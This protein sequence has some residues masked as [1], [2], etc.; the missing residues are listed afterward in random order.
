MYTL[1]GYAIFKQPTLFGQ[2]YKLLGFTRDKPEAA[3]LIRNEHLALP[4]DTVMATEVATSYQNEH[5]EWHAELEHCP[6]AVIIE[7]SL[8]EAGVKAYGPFVNAQEAHHHTW[9]LDS[10]SRTMIL[11]LEH[12]DREL[13]QKSA[14]NLKRLRDESALYHEIMQDLQNL[15]LPHGRCQPRSD[16]ACTH[17]NAQDRLDTALSVYP[18]PRIVCS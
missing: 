6:K 10:F 18:G 2:A 8:W 9:K 4:L 1:H 5:P 7:G 16:K 14:V 15:K 17:C 11:S 13:L 12:P 3:D